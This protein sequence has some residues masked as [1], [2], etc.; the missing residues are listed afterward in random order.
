MPAPV[1]L[2]RIIG[3]LRAGYPEGV[4]PQDYMPILALLARHLTADEVVA[5][6]DELAATL[7]LPAGTDPGAAIAAAIRSVSATPPS[8]FDIERVRDHLES[9]GWELAAD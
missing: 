6:A 4:P 1:V 8:E 2:Q 5:A 3:W 7:P 9:F